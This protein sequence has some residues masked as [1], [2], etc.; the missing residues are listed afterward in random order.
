[1]RT[2]ARES[3]T[4]HGRTITLWSTANPGSQSSL[5]AGIRGGSPGDMVWL[6]T[7]YSPNRINTRSVPS[8]ATGAATP[9]LRP[10]TYYAACGQAYNRNDIKCTGYWL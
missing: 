2:V 7:Q 6:R 1:M 8:G 9:S 5:H 3:V 10:D 4:L